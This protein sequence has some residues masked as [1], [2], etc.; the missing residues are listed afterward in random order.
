MTLKAYSEIGSTIERRKRTLRHNL[1]LTV[2]AGWRREK[3]QKLKQFT[4]R[5]LTKIGL[6]IYRNKPLFSGANVAVTEAITDDDGN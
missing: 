2:W 1:I 4:R 5:R 6:W 3:A